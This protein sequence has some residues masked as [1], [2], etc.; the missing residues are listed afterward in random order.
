MLARTPTYASNI[1]RNPAQTRCPGVNGRIVAD[2]V[3]A[4]PCATMGVSMRRFALM[5]LPVACTTGVNT[6]GSGYFSSSVSATASAGETAA[7]TTDDTSDDADGTDD[8]SDDAEATSP[9]DDSS[10]ASTEPPVDGSGDGS[11][12]D[13]TTAAR[14]GDGSLQGDEACDGQDFGD[15]TC[16]SLG[17]DDGVLGCDPECHVIT[18]AC[19]TCGDGEISLAEACDGNNFDGQTCGSLGFGGGA[20]LCPA[21]CSEIITDGCQPLPTCG[22][23]QLNGGEQ[24]DGNAFGGAT[25]INQGFDMGTIDCTANCTLDTSG[26]MDDLK[27]CGMMGDFCIFDKND[28]Q[29]TCCPAGVGGNMLGICNVFVCV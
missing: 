20:L 5:L 16:G 23:G 10:A 18:D 22:D 29:S 12:A 9:A 11:T 6:S 15:Q 17:F 21:D 13:D 2:G 28:L 24:C 7:A 25:C 26:C 27:N 8:D 1:V 19:F 3:G 4:V 14:C